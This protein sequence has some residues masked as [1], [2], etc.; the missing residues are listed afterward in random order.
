MTYIV[1][2][3]IAMPHEVAPAIQPFAKMPGSSI[4][5]IDSAGLLILRDYSNNIRRMLQLIERLDG[6]GAPAAPS[7][8]APKR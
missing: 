3:K 5:A 6:P 4:M 1:E 2:L 8:P 7:K